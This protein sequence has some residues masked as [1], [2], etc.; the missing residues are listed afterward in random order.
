MVVCRVQDLLE[1]SVRLCCGGV[2]TN[3]LKYRLVEVWC[4]HWE[5]VGVWG[6]WGQGRAV[7]GTDTHD[8]GQVAKLRCV[9][10]GCRSGHGAAGQGPA[11]W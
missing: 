10:M 8:E 2:G 1:G 4:G 11:L 7:W 6:L 5:Q 9:S 3:T